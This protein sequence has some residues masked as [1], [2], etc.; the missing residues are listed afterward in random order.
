MTFWPLTNSD[1]PTDKTFHQFHDL[2]TELDHHPIISGF[3]WAFAT[4][5]AS[6]QGTLTLLDTW[7]R[8]PFWDVL[9]LQLLRP[10][11]S[12]LLC[13]YS[14]FHL[15]IPL[16][17]FSICLLNIFSDTLKI[18]SILSTLSRSISCSFKDIFNIRL[19]ILDICLEYLWFIWRSLQS[20]SLTFN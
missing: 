9:V 15:G 6:Q 12:N 11:S 19:N 4:G 1:F 2:D 20:I 7:F 16:G 18:F 14:T 8:P 5:V 17:T 13:L 3:H 10:D